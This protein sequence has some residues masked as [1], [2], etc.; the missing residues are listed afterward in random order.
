MGRIMRTVDTSPSDE[1]RHA[2]EQTK[3]PCM[4]L[5]GP[6]SGK[7]YVLTHRIAHLLH[8]PGVH[9]WNILA[10]TFTNKA[11]REMTTR[12]QQLLGEG[13]RKLWIGTFHSLFARILRIEAD[14]IG[15]PRDFTIYDNEDSKKL[16]KKIVQELSLSEDIYKPHVQIFKVFDSILRRF[17]V[18]MRIIYE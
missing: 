9:P 16:I 17:P 10:L 12:I 15:L 4:V 18:H 11:A 3:G 7:T 2:I 14:H 8:K 1:Q 5:A 6:G 13:A